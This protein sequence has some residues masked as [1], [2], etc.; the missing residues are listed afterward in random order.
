MKKSIVAILLIT[1]LLTTGSVYGESFDSRAD[2]AVL[3]EASSGQFL[4]EKNADTPLPPAST[5]KIMTLLLAFEA[6][7]RGDIDWDDTTIV[8]RNAWSAE[9]VGSRMF[10]DL[11]QEVSIRDLI[12]G[13]SIVSANDGTVA[14]AEHLSGSEEAFVQQMNQRAQEL[15]MTNTVFRNTSGLPADGH[16]MSA[17]DI[18]ILSRELIV[19]HPGI[20]DIE[21]QPEF[22][23]NDI[24][25]YN[26][27]RRFLSSF[28]GAN[29]LKT[30]WT[31]ESR[32]NLA[33]A[34]LRDGRQLISVV[35]GAESESERVA[36]TSELLNHGFN[37]FSPQTIA[38]KG[39]VVAEVAVKDG[40][41]QVVPVTVPQEVEVAVPQGRENDIELVVAEETL[42]APVE[43]GAVAGQLLVQL[44][45]ETLYSVQL[46]TA[47]EVGRANFFVRG[48]RG[49]MNFITGLFNRS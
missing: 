2:V 36:A 23:F 1:L 44:D 4:Y 12:Y 17:R 13:I 27:N 15:G 48:F 21:T 20:L 37:Q 3:M 7:E 24:H 16:V 19:N 10:L 35:M 25:Q 22:T 18:A 6:L 28:E 41:Q 31:D 45:D 46:Y 11:D 26:W 29:G 43:E 14:L 5:T 9:V 32:F 33:G 39:E 42:T 40:R 30:G 49:I 38:Q 34:A 8:S 47:E